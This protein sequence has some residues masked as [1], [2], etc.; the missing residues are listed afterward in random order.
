MPP[1][2]DNRLFEAAPRE[3]RVRITPQGQQ[4]L[5]PAYVV[6]CHWGHGRDEAGVLKIIEVHAIRPVGLRL[7]QQQ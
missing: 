3:R 2:L 7:T 5:Q 4:N 6:G 1:D